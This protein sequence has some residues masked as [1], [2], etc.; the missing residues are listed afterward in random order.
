MLRPPFLT[1]HHTL[2]VETCCHRAMLDSKV[3]GLL[4]IIPREMEQ[5][6]GFLSDRY[7]FL[8]SDMKGERSIADTQYTV[9]CI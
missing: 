6:G 3:I 8:G 5:M 1:S 9:Y 7:G 2:R 4:Q